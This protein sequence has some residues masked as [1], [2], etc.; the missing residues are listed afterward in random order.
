MADYFQ[1][2]EGTAEAGGSAAAVK[3]DGFKVPPPPGYKPKPQNTVSESANIP[4]KK[5][6]GID[7]LSVISLFIFSRSY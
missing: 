6:R 2:D 5:A 7:K 1:L 4:E 3:S